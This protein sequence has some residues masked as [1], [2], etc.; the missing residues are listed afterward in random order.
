ME[1]GDM[2]KYHVSG[3]IQDFV[4]DSRNMGCIRCI[5]LQVYNKTQYLDT[6]STYKLPSPEVI[7]KNHPQIK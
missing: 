3:L 4:F 2:K 1:N 6:E 5:S 7:K